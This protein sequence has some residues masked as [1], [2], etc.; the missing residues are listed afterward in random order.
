VGSADFKG[1]FLRGRK[2]EALAGKGKT[3]VDRRERKKKKPV[4][5]RENRK[6]G[7]YRYED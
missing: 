5:K 6:I 3:A 1:R 7:R 4:Q 2:R